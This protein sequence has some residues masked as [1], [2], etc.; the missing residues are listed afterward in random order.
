MYPITNQHVAHKHTL[1][2][3]EIII[4]FS[5]GIRAWYSD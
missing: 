4:Y 3:L 5:F 2:N 1:G